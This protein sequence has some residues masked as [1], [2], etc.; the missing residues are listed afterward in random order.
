LVPQGRR[1]VFVNIGLF[2]KARA[3][4]RSLGLK[5]RAE[6]RSYNQSDKRPADI[7][8]KPYNTYLNKGRAGYPDWLG[9]CSR[10]AERKYYIR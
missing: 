3:Y 5:S 1:I 9:Y 8:A 6:W 10:P 4:A 2:K 7:P